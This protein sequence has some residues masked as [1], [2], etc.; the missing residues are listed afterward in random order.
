[1][2][3][4]YWQ[5][6]RMERSIRYALERVLMKEERQETEKK[7]LAI[8]DAAADGIVLMDNDA[9]ISYWNPGAERIFGYSP[10]EAMGREMHLLIAPE[11]FHDAYCF[12]SLRII[13]A[14]IFS[15]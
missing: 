12:I 10:E 5:I 13:S 14:N 1:M 3:F 6:S 11:E 4:S 9:N 15:L 7:L 8:T 2:G